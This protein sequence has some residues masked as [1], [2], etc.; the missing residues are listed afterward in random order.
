MRTKTASSR[1]KRAL[2]VP[3]EQQWDFLVNVENMMKW[4]DTFF[5]D[6]HTPEEEVKELLL[7]A[8]KLCSAVFGVKAANTQ[9]NG[10]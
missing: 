6:V 3:T 2:E 4:V 7:K 10:S 5:S 9:T 1:S 8:Y